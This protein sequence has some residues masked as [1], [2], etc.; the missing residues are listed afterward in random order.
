M[1]ASPTS[2]WPDRTRGAGRAQRW[3]ATL[4]LPVALLLTVL[5][6]AMMVCPAP[7]GAMDIGSVPD[8]AAARASLQVDEATAAGIIAAAER[9]AGLKPPTAAATAVAA[10]QAAGLAPRTAAS[11]RAATLKRAGVL[12]AAARKAKAAHMFTRA[13]TL[14]ERARDLYL[15]AGARRQARVCL[16]GMQDIFMY[17][18]SYSRTRAEMLEVL[19]AM[20]P[21]VPE[22]QRAAW[23]DLPSTE[24]M[25]WDGVKH[26]YYD[27]AINLAYRDVELF[28]TLPD[29]VAGYQKVYDTLQMYEAAAASAS[30]WQPYA[31]PREYDFTQTLSVPRAELPATGDLRAWLPL[32]IIGGPQTDV[33]ITE[34][35]PSTWTALPP[36][37]AQDIGLLSLRVPLA[38]LTGDLN[39]T[40]KVHYAHSAQY[41]KV[42]SGS[43]GAYDRTSALYKKYTTSRGNTTITPSIRRTARRVV[44]DETNPYLKARTLYVYV[45]DKVKYSYVPHLTLWPR[46][47]PESVYVHTRKYGDCGAQSM[48]FSA[49]CR[50][51]G[52]PT[53]TTGGF[54]TFTGKPAGHFWAEF[55]LPNYGWIPVDPTAATLVD[56]LEDVSPVDK[57]VFH[58]FF[59][60]SQDDLRLV[61]QKDTDLPLIPRADM[62][63]AIPLA[64]QMPAATCDGMTYNAGL[65]LSDHWTF[66]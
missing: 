38:Q 41:F 31:E 12:L 65:V 32:P 57:E 18:G 11:A 48:Y 52:V 19:S 36:S 23:L 7:A 26:Y 5:A 58:A 47:V 64:V 1:G 62:R 9:A 6:G 37:I 60:G 20:Y 15:Q 4:V 17:V 28:Q 54:Q 33:R 10:E 51:V 45:L 29:H 25:R 24:S 61:V 50:A 14:Y 21:S 56:Y 22:E 55:Y 44:G 30:P 35:T 40:F 8:L 46:G 43:V 66:E 63:V 49:L 27:V 53:R 34:L 59:F 16:T 42:Q 13:N 39:V 3:W 2:T